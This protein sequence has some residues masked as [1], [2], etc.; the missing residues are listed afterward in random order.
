MWLKQ[1]GTCGLISGSV[2]LSLN[3]SVNNSVVIN[4]SFLCTLDLSC[5]Y[6]LKVPSIIEMLLY[7]SMCT[8]LWVSLSCGR[9]PLFFTELR[10]GV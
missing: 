6:I 8:L 7:M 9:I 3:S 5:F 2:S 4:T 10:T 1:L